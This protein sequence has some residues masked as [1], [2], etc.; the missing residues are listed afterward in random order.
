M[1]S[2]RAS[3]VAQCSATAAP[4][5][6]SRMR[7]MRLQVATISQVLALLCLS[8]VPMTAAGS[9]SGSIKDATGSAVAN[10]RILILTPQRAVVATAT[11]DNDGRFTV[12]NLAEAEYL[13]VA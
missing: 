4:A 9:L 5:W 1:A 13:V 10:A 8:E 2:C 6:S 12:A 7:R 11:S 3:V